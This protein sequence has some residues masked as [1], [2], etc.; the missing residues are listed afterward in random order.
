[1]A[2]FPSCNADYCVCGL[3]EHLRRLQHQR[4]GERGEENESGGER[5]ELDH[6]V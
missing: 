1:M 5:G 2:Y 3:G 4:D 6:G